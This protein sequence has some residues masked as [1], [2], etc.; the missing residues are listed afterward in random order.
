M[1]NSRNNHFY[2]SSLDCNHTALTI[3]TDTDSDSSPSIPPKMSTFGTIPITQKPVTQS[4]FSVRC[5]T[6]YVLCFMMLVFAYGA[7]YVNFS[8]YL[9]DVEIEHQ[10]E[11]DEL[12]VQRNAMWMSYIQER[13]K[14]RRLANHI[15]NFDEIFD[16][17]DFN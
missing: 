17:D 10:A 5:V 3:S 1:S 7:A 12:T 15:E 16:R 2:T 14:F 8:M 4:P 11:I 6:I 9:F 13:S